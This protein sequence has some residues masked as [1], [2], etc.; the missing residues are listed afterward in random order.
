VG[1]GCCRSASKISKGAGY[2][3]EG[4]LPNDV[5]Y[6]SP[7]GVGRGERRGGEGIIIRR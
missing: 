5:A 6:C 4:W 1:L 2:T 7:Q 3:E